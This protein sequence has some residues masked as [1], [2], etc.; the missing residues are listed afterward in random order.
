M[1]KNSKIAQLAIASATV[2]AALIGAQGAYGLGVPLYWFNFDQALQPDTYFA[3]GNTWSRDGYVPS[4]GTATDDAYLEM[5]HGGP[6]GTVLDYYT[7]TSTTLSDGV[8][9]S[10]T[11]SG[12]HTN[13]PGD[14]GFDNYSGFYS[15]GPNNGEGTGATTYNGPNATTTITYNSGSGGAYAQQNLRQLGTVSGVTVSFWMDMT[16]TDT[17]QTVGEEPRIIT[18]SASPGSSTGAGDINAANTL[19]VY[20]LR[21]SSQSHLYAQVD[22]ASNGTNDVFQSYSPPQQGMTTGWVFYA[23]DYSAAA[24]TL[25][26]YE[27][28]TG[29]SA[30]AVLTD[31]NYNVGSISFGSRATLSIGDKNYGGTSP[32]QALYDDVQIYNTSLSPG[33][34]VNAQNDNFGLTWNNTNGS[35]D[36][37]HWDTLSQNWNNGSG[38]A[39]YANG[40]SVTFNDAN[41]NNYAVTL[42][43]TVSPGSV[44]VNATGNYSITGTGTIADA[45]SFTKSGTDTLTIGTALSVGSMSITSGTLKLASGVSGGSGP[46]V[47]STINLASLSITG[48]GELDINN[49]HLI[50][51]YGASDPI[52]TIAGY[53]A[54]GYNTGN[55][56]GPGIISSVALTNASG[57]KYGVGYADGN[58]GVVSGL[59]SGQ[60]E[61]AYT[62]LGDANLDGLVNGSDFNILAANFNQS[63]T[64]WDQGDFNYDGLVNASDFNE[65]AANFNQGVSGAASAGD[66]AAL[67][68]F[69]AANG[70]SLTTV[71]EPTAAGLLTLGT[72]GVLARRRQRS[73]R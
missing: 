59:T 31:T 34:V 22:G 62:L 68:A 64:G 40:N 36:G 50:I 35:G 20:Y 5:A 6:A 44:T 28:T 10:G 4:V 53:I 66:V 8:T 37:Q 27:G 70:I 47:S 39:L 16:G 21:G 13:M 48:S 42:N 58:D 67:D 17:N 60:I 32:E 18:L 7:G 29:Q 24:D 38:P 19:S 25:T 73:C 61:V 26:V 1:R 46:A 57:L 12:G 3:T 23:V 41:N 45:G 30:T 56:N 55:W 72:I 49:N 51:T 63:I 9:P 33:D 11:G 43:S 71:P 52:T 65:L 2:S 14:Y 54:S 69:A 15:G